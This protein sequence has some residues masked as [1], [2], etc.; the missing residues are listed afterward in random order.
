MTKVKEPVGAGKCQPRSSTPG[1]GRGVAPRA[2]SR[3]RRLGRGIAGDDGEE[4][5]TAN[6]RTAGRSKTLGDE[7]TG[8]VSVESNDGEGGAGRER[9]PP[10]TR[11]HPQR[12]SLSARCNVNH[13]RQQAHRPPAIGEEATTPQAVERDGGLSGY[14]PRLS[15][16]SPRYSQIVAGVSLGLALVLHQLILSVEPAPSTVILST[17]RVPLRGT[18]HPFSD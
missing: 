5:E 6:R 2:G 17:R 16:R 8:T 4:G 9:I 7:S 11:R 14:L 10:L 15:Q 18:D 12:P 1:G 3:Q 13:R